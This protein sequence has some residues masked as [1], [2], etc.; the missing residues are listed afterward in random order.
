M[1][2]VIYYTSCDIIMTYQTPWI[3]QNDNTTLELFVGSVPKRILYIFIFKHLHWGCFWV[4]GRSSAW[5]PRRGW[6]TR[7]RWWPPRSCARVA[8]SRS[9]RAET[10]SP[11]SPRNLKEMS[12]R[13]TYRWR[14]LADSVWLRLD[15]CLM[16]NSKEFSYRRWKYRSTLKTHSHWPVTY[17][18]LWVL[19]EQSPLGGLVHSFRMVWSH[20]MLFRHLKAIFHTRGH[21]LCSYWKHSCSR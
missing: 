10:E 21:L 11:Y 18:Q 17:G 5:T 2:H 1:W 15:R 12:R 8:S 6:G 3:S 20:L 19:I 14:W 13:S 4:R 16:A 9:R 7:I